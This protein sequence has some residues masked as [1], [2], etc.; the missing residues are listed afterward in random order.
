MY[1]KNCIKNIYPPETIELPKL[2]DVL[3]IW[4]PDF[5]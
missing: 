4:K 1:Y 3:T 2:F 5:E